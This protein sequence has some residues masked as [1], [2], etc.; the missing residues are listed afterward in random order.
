MGAEDFVK[1][2]IHCRADFAATEL[3]AAAELAFYRGLV[4]CGLNNTSG[5]VHRRDLATLGPRRVADELVA[6]GYWEAAPTGWSFRSWDKW[7][8]DWEQIAE[9]RR[10]DAERKRQKRREERAA[11]FNDEDG[12]AA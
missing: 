12:D 2:A 9:K 8:G 3:S 6:K 11:L 7:Q 5:V 4:Y 1:L 10:R